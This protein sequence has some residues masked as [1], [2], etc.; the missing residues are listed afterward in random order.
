M[1]R[2]S[3]SIP[4]AI[5]LVALTA[6][7]E[8][9][10]RADGSRDAADP[11][12]RAADS[13]SVSPELFEP[14]VISDDRWQWR[15]SFAPDEES[16]FYAVSDGFFP[17]TRNATIFVTDRRE[18]GG[19]DTPEIAPFSGTH[20]DID[21]FITPD[22]R[23]LY[24][25][26]SRPVDGTPKEDFDIWFV[27]RGPSGW[28]TPTHAGPEVNSD[29]DELYPSATASGTLYFASGPRSP[30]PD[31]DWN[32]YRAE[33][34]G[35]AFASREPLTEINTDLP[36]DPDDPTA[37]WEYNPEISPGGRTLV[38][39]SLRPGGHGS[40]D[41]YV[42]RLRNGGWSAP[43]NL[44]PPV[45]TA[46]DEFHPTVSRDGTT[47]YFVRTILSPDVVPSDFYSVPV[48]AL[49]VEL[50]PQGDG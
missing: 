3:T 11:D 33:R 5:V 37:D 47:L 25:S 40:G 44:G 38:F 27:E 48:G 36:F 41:L 29:L 31:A 17:E 35:R 20:H 28:G 10:P 7:G 45:N 8:Q 13:E 6:C 49:A 21:P 50:R 19:W 30:T 2:S 18:D 24:F 16:A 15:I 39:T 26:S 32:L 46:Q 12:A 4:V 9:S 14:G 34:A 23:R 22:G 43:E 1:G 42:S